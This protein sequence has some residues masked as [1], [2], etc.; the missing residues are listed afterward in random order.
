MQKY[1]DSI[2]HSQMSNVGKIIDLLYQQEN[3]A[4]PMAEFVGL[5]VE[6]QGKQIADEIIRDLTK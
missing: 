5:V 2:K 4:T 6:R 3:L 1:G